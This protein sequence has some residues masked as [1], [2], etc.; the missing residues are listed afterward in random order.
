MELNFD[1]FR[2]RIEDLEYPPNHK[3]D[4][5]TFEPI[6]VM[7]SRIETIQRIA[8]ELVDGGDSLLDVGCNKGFI[9]FHLRNKYKKITAIDVNSKINLNI[10]AKIGI[11]GDFI[12]SIQGGTDTVFVYIAGTKY[13]LIANGGGGDVEEAPIDGSTYGRNN[14]AWTIISAGGGDVYF[15]DTTTTIATKHD[16]DTVNA[17]VDN[18]RLIVSVN[19]HDT[20]PFWKDTLSTGKIATKYDVAI[21]GGGTSY[22]SIYV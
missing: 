16:I 3:Y 12:D 9:S 15:T 13:N 18:T 19:L 20:V 8:P 14:A 17:K 11:N 2:K 5:E 7:K 4:P 21:G 6:G 10:G 1:A 22:D